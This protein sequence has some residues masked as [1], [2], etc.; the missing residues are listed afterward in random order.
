MSV[1]LTGRS[2]AKSV[3]RTNGRQR[4]EARIGQSIL[5]PP[6]EWAPGSESAISRTRL[7]LRHAAEPFLCLSS[8]WKCSESAYKQLSLGTT[9]NSLL[10]FSPEVLILRA[11]PRIRKALSFRLWGE[12][13]ALMT[14]PNPATHAI[15]A[16]SLNPGDRLIGKD[17]EGN[18]AV[19]VVISAHRKPSGNGHDSVSYVVRQ[20]DSWTLTVGEGALTGEAPRFRLIDAEEVPAA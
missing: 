9:G 10:Q 13:Y 12:L 11:L 8:A 5:S 2:A 4:R 14:P 20:R 19:F 7:G 1:L 18:D 17:A 6:S 16:P 3:C 15:C